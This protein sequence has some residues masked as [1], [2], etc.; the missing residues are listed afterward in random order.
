MLPTRTVMKISISIYAM[1]LVTMTSC[2]PSS[3]E[4]QVTIAEIP[5]HPWFNT[6]KIDE[7]VW[8]ISDHGEDNIYLLEGRDSALLIDTGI[9]AVNLVDYLK[10]I[11]SLPLIVI[12]THGHPDH[13]GSNNQFE[14][15][16]AHAAEFEMIRNFTAWGMHNTMLQYMV[17]VPLPDSVKFI[18]TDT[19]YMAR[20]QAVRDG[21]VIDLGGRPIEVIHLPGHTPGSICLLDRQ[22]KLLFTGDNIKSLVWMHMEESESLEIFLTSLEKIQARAGE[23]TTLLPGHEGALDG[24]F[25]KEQI[26]CVQNILSGQCEGKSYESVV[27]NGLLCE[28]KRAQIAYSPGKLK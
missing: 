6:E 14:S 16:R 18:P 13:V 1:M 4:Q 27:G 17:Q 11:T 12:N 22:R 28:H 23:F 2:T 20:L 5:K 10:N 25:I 24:A 7:S 26:E 3:K 19:L 21:F 8:R 15:V 9:G